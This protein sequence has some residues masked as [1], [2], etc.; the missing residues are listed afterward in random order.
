[1]KKCYLQL[2][3]LSFFA[4]SLSNAYAQ[5]GDCTLEVEVLNVYGEDAGTP[6]DPSDDIFFADLLVTG[7]SHTCGW[8]ADD[9]MSNSGLF[10]VVTTIG[11]YLIV[12]GDLNFNIFDTTNPECSIQ[13]SVP[14]S[15]IDPPDCPLLAEV[16]DVYCD[17]NGTPSDPNDDQFTFDLLVTGNIG[18]TGWVLFDGFDAVSG[19]YGVVTSLGPY[20]TFQNQYQFDIQDLDNSDCA[21]T[22]IVSSPECGPDPA[23]PQL[24]VESTQGIIGNELCLEVRAF[25]LVQLMGLQFSLS[26]STDALSFTQILDPGILP[27]GWMLDESELASGRLGFTASGAPFSP[28]DIPD[29]TVI[30]EVCYTF[31]GGCSDVESA[32]NPVGTIAIIDNQVSG[33]NVNPGFV[34]DPMPE[35]TIGPE[36]YVCGGEIV[37]LDI[38]PIEPLPDYIIQWSCDG[39][40][41]CTNC[42]SIEILPT[43]D[44]YCTLQIVNTTNGCTYSYDYD[45]DVLQ[46]PVVES[47]AI[48]NVNCDGTGF[49]RAVFEVNGTPPFI[50]DGQPTFI[51]GTPPVEMVLENLSIGNYSQIIFDANGCGTQVEFLIWQDE[52][53]VTATEIIPASCGNLDGAIF[54]EVD[55]GSG[56]YEYLWSNASVSQNQTELDVGTY[57]VTVNDLDYD[58]M[59]TAQF[60]VPNQLIVS[61]TPDT[62]ICTEDCFHLQVDAPNAVSYQWASSVVPLSCDTCAAPYLL[63]TFQSDNFQVTVTGSGGCE[64]TASVFVDVRSYLDFGLLEFSNSPVCEGDT[65]QFYSNV[66]NGMSY[67]WTGPGSFYSEES[68]PTI[69]NAT[70]LN[71][72]TY[73][74]EIIDDIGC[75]VSASTDV[76]VHEGLEISITLENVVCS[77]ECTGSVQIDVIGGTPPYQYEI[78]GLMGNSSEFTDLCPGDYVLVVTDANSCST[79]TDFFISAMGGLSLSVNAVLASSCMG[80]TGSIELQVAGGVLPYTY[81]WS[82]DNNLN[83]NVANSLAPGIYSVTVTDLEGC[84]AEVVIEVG[85]TPEVIISPDQEICYGESTTLEVSGANIVAVSWSPTTGLSNSTGFITEAMP[86]FTTTYTATVTDMEGCSKDVMVTVVVNPPACQM[87]YEANV[88]LGETGQWC[89]PLLLPIPFEVTQ[90]LLG[91]LHGNITAMPGPTS[92]CLSFEGIL[93]GIDSVYFEF[94]QQGLPDICFDILLIVNV[95]EEE[96][97]PGDTN[98]DGVVN[99]FD[100]LNI[101]L[102]IDSTGPTRPNANL[103]WNGQPAAAWSQTTPS[104]NTN[105]AHIDTDGNGSI[106]LDDTTAINLHWGEM[107]N[108]QSGGGMDWHSVTD[109][110]IPFYVQPDTLY[111]GTTIALPL[112]FGTELEPAQNIYGLAFTI[113]YDPAIIAPGT[114]HLLMGGSWLGNPEVDLFYMQRDFHSEGHLRV[115]V[116]RTDGQNQSG[117]GLF[118]YFIV[119][120]EDDILLWQNPDQ[121]T[122]NTDLVTLFN[123]IDVQVIDFNEEEKM[124]DTRTTQSEVITDLISEGLQAEPE[125]NIFPN[126]ADKLIYLSSEN[127]QAEH[128]I[129]RRPS[130]SLVYEKSR[131]EN[132]LAIDTRQ[133]PS[134]L[135]L[136]QLKTNKG[137]INRRF[138]VIH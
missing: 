100:V 94:C 121:D 33:I 21:T 9:P 106:N 41:V 55:G 32:N 99:N 8:T 12:N 71:S 7:D 70:P 105:Y 123:I 66:L 128:L 129:I 77:N 10:G 34:S 126:P 60:E 31:N 120:I 131:P 88:A 42:T 27:Q 138:L 92:E 127:L 134:G 59:A 78:L 89:S 24:Q 38:S 35:P 125:I 136:L 56:N 52:L 72:G 18:S 29:N 64:Q 108:L 23:Q 111:E 115:G 61:I 107:H 20:P 30:L 6:S 49:G 28:V 132:S 65:L 53:T 19:T 76:A 133:W 17:D 74:L 22:I 68:Q 85:Q 130:G 57:F 98:D 44:M 36:I 39:A 104:S 75:E 5:T 119:T 103:N 101:G 40:V 2:L 81:L 50:F 14:T 73:N 87:Q 117:F 114:A 62:T 102:G 3:L 91:P 113:E 83:T 16:L 4:L 45:I 93:P 90:I 112:I 86:P 58:C 124:V 43:E 54:I 135:Y 80:N 51:D 95:L 82:H 15:S 48:T 1:M 25:E 13:V 110:G 137:I 116:S 84:H 63:E 118:G 122:R 96:V 11:P 79:T 69:P 46:Q 97:W 67:T 47:I 37:F 26:W 109:E